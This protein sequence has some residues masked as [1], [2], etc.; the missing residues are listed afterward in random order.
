[1]L[2]PLTIYGF[3]AGVLENRA[4][5]TGMLRSLRSSRGRQRPIKPPVRVVYMLFI[6]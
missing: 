2:V 4:E 6:Y 3:P 5:A 1:M